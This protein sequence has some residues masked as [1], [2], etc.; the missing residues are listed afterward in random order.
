M[1]LNPAA[2]CSWNLLNW[3]EQLKKIKREKE[4]VKIPKAQLLHL[5]SVSEVN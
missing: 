4:G 2:P 1:I 5:S 3:S